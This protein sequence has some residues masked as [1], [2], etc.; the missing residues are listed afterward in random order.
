MKDIMDLHAL[1]QVKAECRFSDLGGDPEWT[2]LLVIKL[3]R[4]ASG[5]DILPEEPDLVVELEV[6]SGETALVCPECMLRLC[7]SDV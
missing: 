4:R 3:V 1:R 7:L 6:R 2:K 5:L